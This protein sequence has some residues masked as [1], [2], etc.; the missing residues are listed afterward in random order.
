M[1]NEELYEGEVTFKKSKDEIKNNQFVT[2][3][4]NYG[5]VSF[6][7]NDESVVINWLNGKGVTTENKNE[8][9]SVRPRFQSKKLHGEIWKTTYPL[10]FHILDKG[11]ILKVKTKEY[12]KQVSIG[13]NVVITDYKLLYE[14]RNQL[15]CNAFIIVDIK[16]NNNLII[17]GNKGCISISI[18]VKR[19]QISLKDKQDKFVLL[20]I[21]CPLCTN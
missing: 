1:K 2:D 9:T 4:F 21:V 10:L 19:T 5:F 15:Q 7:N 14:R 20:D 17:T 8:L 11:L 18:E 13:D 6:T 12:R 16:D 3:G